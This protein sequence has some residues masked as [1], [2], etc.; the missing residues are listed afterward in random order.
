MK[1]VENIA[2]L[3][4]SKIEILKS[5]TSIIKLETKLAA[6][7]IFPLIMNVCLLFV[8]LLS[9][10]LSSMTLLGYSFHYLFNNTFISL[11]LLV[12]LNLIFFFVLYHS[13]LMN[14][15]KMS[16]EKTREYFSN[17]VDDKHALTKTDKRPTRNN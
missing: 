5:V 13:L 7:S 10:W 16:F 3:V 4:S 12:L 8:V 6:L 17:T 2:G 15:K 9:L 14:L 11:G 1:I